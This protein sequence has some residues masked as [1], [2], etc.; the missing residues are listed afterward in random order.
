MADDTENQNATT[1]E[2]KREGRTLSDLADLGT[3]TGVTAIETAAAAPAGPK[4]DAQ[5]RAYATGRRKNA[6]ARVWLKPGKGVVTVQVRSEEH[7]SE[8]QSLMR[9]SYAVF[10]LKQR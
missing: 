1:D 9:N 5:G 3:A 10:C 8:L 2:T 7:T 6:V 4:L